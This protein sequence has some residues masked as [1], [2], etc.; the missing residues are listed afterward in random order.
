MRKIGSFVVAGAAVIVVV[1]GGPALAVGNDKNCS[2]F[3]TQP[4][5]QAYFNAYPGDPSRLDS[6]HNGVACQNL[7]AGTATGRTGTSTATPRTGSTTAATRPRSAAVSGTGSA[8]GITSVATGAGGTASGPDYALP[9]GAVGAA[10]LASG[11]L[12]LRGRRRQA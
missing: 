1:S 3:A 7:P 11:G 10:L 5:A 6:D 4:Q 2:D 12:V 8:T 9:L